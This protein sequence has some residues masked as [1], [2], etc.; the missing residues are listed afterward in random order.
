MTTPASVATAQK[1]RGFL[2]A[3]HISQIAV[4]RSLGISK[5]I[6]SRWLNGSYPGDC[7]RIAEAVEGYIRRETERLA[8]PPDET[9]FLPITTARQIAEI[10]HT[11]HLQGDLGIAYGDAGIGKTTAAKNYAEKNSDV[12]LIESDPTV[13]AR[14]LVSKLYRLLLSDSTGPLN[15]MFESLI[16][17]LRGTGRLIIIDEAEHLP[18]KALELLRRLRDLTGIGLLLIGMPRLYS[19]ITGMKNDFKQLSSRVGIAAR[20]GQLTPDDAA[21]L[22]RAQIP[23]ADGKIVTKFHT[24][25]SGNA[26][27][28]AKLLDASLRMAKFNEIP[29]APDLIEEAASLLVL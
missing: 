4:S 2:K 14:V 5:T 25:T 28:L 18:V 15:Q 7:P 9:G 10:A 13:T 27:S 20:L 24:L 6:L 23:D 29:V 16:D 19:N 1:L 26:R 17:R 21:A 12:I 22:V 3:H 8:L 11:V